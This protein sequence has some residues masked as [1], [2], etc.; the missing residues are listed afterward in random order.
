MILKKL[1]VA[2]WKM[3]V[4]SKKGLFLARRIS[5]LLN[6][7][8]K[9]DYILLPSTQSI[10]YI[11]TKLNKNTVSFG[12]QDCSPFNTGAYTGDVAA[13]M[14]KEIGCKYVLLGHSERRKYYKED[15]EILKRKLENAFLN[16][17]K[18]IFCI[19]ES[20]K[21]YNTGDTKKVIYRQIKEVFENKVI[22][23][24][25][26]I[27]YEP[28]WAIGTNRIPKI[29]EIET[30]HGYIKEIFRKNYKEKNICVIY[31]GSVNLSNSK[32]IFNAKNVDGGLIGGAALKA[33]EFKKILDN[34]NIL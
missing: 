15:K 21:D 20:L 33:N 17:L 31:G 23:K 5:T 30:I 3:N 18:V 9:K 26:V 28:V 8:V 34:L 27:A 1:L 25:L 22:S 24:N 2:N 10:Y 16:K 4:G 14:L 12:A 29:E 7:R 19:G 13:A 11:K 32:D 6:N